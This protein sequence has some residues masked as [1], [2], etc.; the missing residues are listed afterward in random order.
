[1]KITY[2]F[3]IVAVNVMYMDSFIIKSVPCSWKKQVY[4]DYIY[5]LCCNLGTHETV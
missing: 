5:I 2:A 4:K 1:M 3:Y